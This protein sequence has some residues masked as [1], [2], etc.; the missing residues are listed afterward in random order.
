[1]RRS[2]WLALSALI[3]SPTP[4]TAHFR[5]T[6]DR[7]SRLIAVMGARTGTGL[8]RPDTRQASRLIRV[9][10]ASTRRATCHVPPPDRHMAQ[11]NTARADKAPIWRKR[12]WSPDRRPG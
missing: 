11:L 1:M 4:V 8:S 9:N 7:E 10:L 2:S 12:R 5:P 6:C 3:L